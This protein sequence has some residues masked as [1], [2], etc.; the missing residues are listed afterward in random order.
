MTERSQLRSHGA[1]SA[2]TTPAGSPVKS[3]AS[4]A[5][6]PKSPAATSSAATSSAPTSSAATTP[7]GSP[8]KAPPSETCFINSLLNLPR[9]EAMK[10]V[11]KLLMGEDEDKGEDGGGGGEGGVGGGGGRAT[12]DAEEKEKERLMKEEEEEGKGNFELEFVFDNFIFALQRGFSLAECLALLPI[13][14]Q[15]LS[16]ACAGVPRTEALRLFRDEAANL[17]AQNKVKKIN[18]EKFCPQ[19]LDDLLRHYR[20]FNF[21]YTQARP[22]F[23]AHMRISVTAPK[24]PPPLQQA[25]PLA[26]W[27]YENKWNEI[28]TREDQETARRDSE[29]QKFSEETAERMVKVEG[30]VLE[31]ILEAPSFKDKNTLEHIVKDIADIHVEQLVGNMR[32][33]VNDIVEKLTFKLEKT[34]L[35]RPQMLGPPPRYS[36][37]PLPPAPRPTKEPKGAPGAAPPEA[38]KSTQKASAKNGAK[39]K[40]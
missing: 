16:F 23:E 9:D 39:K 4:R 5:A 32:L 1:A 37:A 22:P 40:K 38:S 30:Q 26:V 7:G 6:A 8:V 10:L 25:K 2:A 3:S 36:P 29:R 17:V 21:V 28:Q 27:T 13:T 24:P 18:L 20:L 33:Q 12:G 31:T 15:M 19:F 14:R 34:L 35:P 11:A